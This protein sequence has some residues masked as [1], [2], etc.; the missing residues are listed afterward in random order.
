MSVVSADPANLFRSKPAIDYEWLITIGKLA[1]VADFW[2]L[3]PRARLEEEISQAA[4]CLEAAR[5]DLLPRHAFFGENRLSFE[6][7]SNYR[8]SPLQVF[9]DV[10][11]PE[12]NGLC[13][14]LA[15]KIDLLWLKR[16]VLES[17]R[18]KRPPVI[19]ANDLREI[20]KLVGEESVDEETFFQAVRDNFEQRG[21]A[22][23]IWHQANEQ[24]S[25]QRLRYRCQSGWSYKRT[26][27]KDKSKT[28]GKVI[29]LKVRV[30]EY[31]FKFLKLSDRFN[32][33]IEF[34]WEY[35]KT[36]EPIEMRFYELMQLWRTGRETGGVSNQVVMDYGLFAALFPLPAV[37][38]RTEAEHQVKKIC[39]R[40]RQSGY[41]RGYQIIRLQNGKQTKMQLCFEF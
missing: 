34:N 38:S 14:P 30:N 27:T 33:N 39:G 19:E 10:T 17:N 26:P 31:F 20:M 21:E 8:D 7:S 41:L 37:K 22:E 25:T 12:K 16:L 3:P 36:L 40:H 6:L 29:N 23:I 1:Q 15:Y 24:K 35:L 4:A 9:W 5:L 13:G 11:L 18:R 32:S 2:S 28:L